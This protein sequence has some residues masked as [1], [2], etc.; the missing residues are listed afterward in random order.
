MAQE[1]WMID[2]AKT[3]DIEMV[4]NLKVAL[5]GGQV[6]VIGH[7]E[8]GAR[9]EVHS[10]DGKPLKITL[11]GDTLDIDH[12]QLNWDNFIDVFK[13]F[14]GSARADVSIMVPRDVALKFGV[15][16]AK[17]LISGLTKNAKISTVTGDVVVDDVAADLELNAVSGELAVRGHRGDIAAHTVSGDVTASGEINRFRSDAVSGEV[18]LD[19]TGVP[20]EVRVK[21]VSGNIT[22]RLAAGV[23]AQ[24]KVN[25]IAGRLQLD[26]S[27]IRGIRGQYTGKF[28][29]LDGHWLDFN[30]STVSGNVAVLHGAEVSA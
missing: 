1:K 27:E 11:D 21:S 12:P 30:A 20:D 6:D 14:R 26:D 15:V 13:S 29:D 24:Y 23:A 17:G 4:R 7:D 28:G 16:S 10:V 18:Y 19:V 5:I 22:V 25:T 2:G 9:V 3:I 8:P